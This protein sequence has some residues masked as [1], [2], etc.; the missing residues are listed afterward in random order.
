MSFTNNTGHKLTNT[1]EQTMVRYA[2]KLEEA[3]NFSITL[4][5]DKDEEEYQI[6][7]IDPYGDAEG[8]PWT[9]WNDFV[10]DTEPVIARALI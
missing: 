7:L 5:Y 9:D 10:F 8:D 1:M 4:G 6:F 3:T 2:D